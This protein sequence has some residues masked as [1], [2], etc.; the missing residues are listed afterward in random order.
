MPESEPESENAPFHRYWQDWTTAELAAVDSERLIAVLPVGA[1]E[2]HGPHLPLSTDAVLNRA[3]LHAA[4][5]AMPADLPAVILPPQE[6]G[7]SPE[8]V[9]FPG[10]LTLQVS[11]V[12]R[13]WTDIGD[14]LARAGLRKLLIFNSHGGQPQIMNLVARDL[15]ARHGMLAAHVS[16]FDFGLPDGLFDED[17]LTHGIHGGAIET[18][19]M[20]HAA[21][22]AVR[23]D[24][25]AEFPS[26]AKRMA[27]DNRW[28]RPL[29][30]AAFG[31]LTEDLNPAG[32]VGDATEGDAEKGRRIIEHAA[33]GLVQTLQELDRVKS[34]Q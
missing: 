20:L 27:D 4:I 15:R 3:V 19:M 28:L 10:T 33:S 16:W 34:P 8:H 9:S 14:S 29:G 32:V 6:I 11:T 25:L 23:L 13:L 31:W 30:P 7:L 1:I 22:S 18:S 26:E 5:A 24:R 21:P 17:E 12:I 2:Q